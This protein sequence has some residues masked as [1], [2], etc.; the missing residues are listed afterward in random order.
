MRTDRR[1]AMPRALS[2]AL[3]AA[4][5]A[6]ALAAF[7][8][9][10]FCEDPPA[11]P[12]VRYVAPQAWRSSRS[13]RPGPAAREV[14]VSGVEARVSIIESVAVTD[15]LIRLENKSGSALES[16]LLLPVP[17]GAAVRSFDFK[18]KGPEPSAEILPEA[19][20]RR[21]YSSIVARLRDPALLEFAGFS[22]L[23]SSV[24]PVPAGG[25]QAVRVVYEHI[26]P[27]EGG[28]LEY[29]LPRTQRLSD[30]QVPFDVIVSVKS[31][32]PVS[33][34]Y[35]PT[36]PL[37]LESRGPGDVEA[38][39][40]DSGRTEPGSFVLV[41]LPMQNDV[42]A[43][44]LAHPDPA[45]G[46]TFM[47][48][49]G[50]PACPKRAAAADVKREVTLV[51]DRSGSMS[52]PKIEQA[53]AA[54]LM[55]LESLE[56][57][58]Y[59]NI[60]AYNDS[61]GLFEESAVRK[62]RGTAGRARAFIASLQ[63][64]GGTNLH[65]ALLE[66]LRRPSVPGTLPMVLL[67]SDGVPTVGVTSESLI[68]KAAADANVH[69][70]RIFTFGVGHD[71]NAPLLDVIAE[72]SR[73][74]MTVVL[75]EENVERKVSALFERLSGPVF[76]SLEIASISR[77]G[78][79][80]PSAV[81]DLAPSRLP[82]MFSGDRLVVLGRYAEAG[83]IG[84]R[85]SGCFLGGPRAFEFHFDTSSA[86][87]RNSFVARLW[88]TRRIALMIDEIRQS[89][90]DEAELSSSARRSAPHP[91][92]S[93]NPFSSAGPG[94]PAPDPRTAELVGEIVRLSMKYGV[95]TEYTA[96][97]ALEGSN[98][99][100]PDVLA[101]EAYANLRAWAVNNRSG[102]HANSQQSN[103]AAQRSQ[104][105]SNGRNAG[106]D[107]DMKRVEIG[108]VQQMADSAFFNLRGSWVESGVAARGMD[109][110]PDEVVSFGSERFERILAALAKAGRQGVLSLGPGAVFE[111]DGKVIRIDDGR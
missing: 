54:L 23:K 41:V 5:A 81:S 61:V 74:R 45:G 35:S 84:F 4:S 96:F 26:L 107:R 57:G 52:G 111:L 55:V 44:L 49:A 2:L 76:S 82:D 91:G 92:W 46:G 70:R 89:G 40:E 13:F 95:L 109:V 79:T 1:H 16:V 37:R 38:A 33:A 17:E 56:D 12:E 94:R 32:K 85:I 42:S 83:P 75:P 88:A 14:E 51:L 73:G 21:E 34:V 90:A 28:R 6:A 66:P 110:R 104:E 98:L 103:N 3:C 86:S 39:V 47:L 65:D 62:D 102:I 87:V 99:A 43:T 31:A 101:R 8:H 36:H 108:G 77:S 72:S 25:T 78:L 69:G 71:V 60:V 64:G 80:R 93:G 59:F 30:S 48:L 20:A 9:D 10:C 58:E 29:V 68:R 63:A 19:G 27:A 15:L 11:A 24:F 50:L 7:A 105:S 18:G 97:L 100:S 53:K 106:F 67:L 22:L